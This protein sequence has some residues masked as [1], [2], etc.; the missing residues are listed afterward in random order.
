MLVCKSNKKLDTFYSNSGEE[1]IILQYDIQTSSEE[2]EI[3]LYFQVNKLD[4][5]VS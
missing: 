3:L 4:C 5:S 1:A 2:F